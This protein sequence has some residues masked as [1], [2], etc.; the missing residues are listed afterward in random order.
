M[1]PSP[2]GVLFIL[3]EWI[4][5]I[6]RTGMNRMFPSPYGVLFI[7]IKVKIQY[8]SKKTSIM[9][10]SPYGV[11]FILMLYIPLLYFVLHSCFRLLTEYYSFLL[12]IAY[13]EVLISQR[14][15]FRLLTEYYSFL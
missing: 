11:L 12:A 10:P 9:F 3:M 15:S 2:Y 7:L 8:E 14:K 6:D 5:T 4:R 13:A 1:F